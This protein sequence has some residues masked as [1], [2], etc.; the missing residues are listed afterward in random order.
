MRVGGGNEEG[1]E[2]KGLKRMRREILQREEKGLMGRTRGCEEVGEGMR[3]TRDVR[4]D[5]END[6]GL[7]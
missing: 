3:K 5:E 7:K 2:G 4:R 1:W 6:R